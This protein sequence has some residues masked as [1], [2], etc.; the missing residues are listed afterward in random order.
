MII[1]YAGNRIDEPDRTPSRFPTSNVERVRQEI[2]ALLDEKRPS[3]V[4][5]A[6]AAG[7]DLI[8][9][10]EARRAAIPAHIVLP[11][12]AAE[13]RR[14]S[15]ADQDP[16]WAAVFDHEIEHCQQLTEHDLSHYEDWY[17]RGND[18]ILDA[19]EQQDTN[20]DII[21]ALVVNPP[22]DAQS[23]TGDL[24]HKAAKRNWPT[25]TVDPT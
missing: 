6:A 11:L 8:I 9:L 16:E 23:A 24:H 1:V 5:G 13:F 3:C 22:A 19:A 12:P 17:L 7:A 18:L 14:L 15:V 4:V 25:I 2:R 20:H 21:T 10:S